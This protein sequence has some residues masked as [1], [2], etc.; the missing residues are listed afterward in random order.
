V[1]QTILNQTGQPVPVIALV[2]ATYLTM[3]LLT[4]L[5]MNIYNR[6]VQILE[7]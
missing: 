2:M 6:Y 1:S 3:S 5:I 7:K 4:S